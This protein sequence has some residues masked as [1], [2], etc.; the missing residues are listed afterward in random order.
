LTN[1]TIPQRHQVLAL[2]DAG[3]R[4]SA[5]ARQF[6]VTKRTLRRLVR[7]FR[8]TGSEMTVPDPEDLGVQLIARIGG[9]SRHMCDTEGNLPQRRQGLYPLIAPSTLRSSETV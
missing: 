3:I 9:L 7:H 1:L 5:V 4:P 8:D 6:N 2:L